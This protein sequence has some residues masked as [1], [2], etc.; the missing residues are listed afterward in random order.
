MGFLVFSLRPKT[1]DGLVTDQ[2]R[3]YLSSVISPNQISTVCADISA[4]TFPGRGRG[5]AG[6]EA[7]VG[8]CLGL[9][10]DPEKQISHD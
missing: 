1:L 2:H 8:V 10:S 5:T 7:L 4:P 6:G 9:I 3:C